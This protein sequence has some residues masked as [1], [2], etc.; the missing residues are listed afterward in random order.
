MLIVTN[1]EI[2][3]DFERAWLIFL[4]LAGNRPDGGRSHRNG[5]DVDLKDR[6]RVGG[7]RKPIVRT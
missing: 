4:G 5:V 7:G 1:P 3:Q 6:S 2:M